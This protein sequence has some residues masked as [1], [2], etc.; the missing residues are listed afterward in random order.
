MRCMEQK[1]KTL[2]VVLVSWFDS[3][4]I[5][6]WTPI[7][8]VESVLQLT[9]SC[10]FLVKESENCIVLALSYDEQTESVHNFI[11]IPILCIE[12]VR[13]LCLPKMTLK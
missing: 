4:G 1:N 3:M 10:G 9:Y 12:E 6:E 5:L 11:H 2:K 7:E 8:D 13:E